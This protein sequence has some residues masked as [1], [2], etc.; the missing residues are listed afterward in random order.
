M[1]EKKV[2]IKNL[3][4][5]YI[6]MGAGKPF[7]ILHGWRSR[8]DRWQK[9]GELL[10]E[11]KFK[12]I[13]PD[14]PGFGKSQEPESAWS[15]DN[16]VEWAKELSEKIP[17]IN[18]S[19]YLLGHSFGGTLAVNFTIKYNQKVENLF[20][21]S[22]SCIRKKTN[23]KKF[24][25]VIS[26]FIKIFSFLPYY[27]EFRKSVYKYII[28]KSDYLYQ[29]GVMEDIYLKV[30][31]DDLSHELSFIKVPTII[32]WGDKDTITPLE[33]AKLI[34]KKIEN[35]KLVIIQGADHFLNIKI[36]E[37]LASKILENL[38]S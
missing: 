33:Q 24:L 34:N 26:K 29:S 25:F 30:I 13:I 2:F 3:E 27:Q 14:L 35:S 10:S 8:S 32:I 9:I 20:I 36:P 6:V 31:S 12:V 38:P 17:E 22:A 18:G 5:H 15:L 37:I 11:K 19:F 1:E 7:L 21:V 23:I 28:K 4:V 16:Y